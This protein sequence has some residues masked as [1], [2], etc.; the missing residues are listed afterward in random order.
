MCGSYYGL[1]NGYNTPCIKCLDSFCLY[2]G[3]NYS[4]CSACISGYVLVNL[5]CT[6]CFTTCLTC[7][8]STTNCTSCIMG[9]Y[10]SNNTCVKCSPNC[11]TCTN[12]T[13]CQNCAVGYFSPVANICYICPLVCTTCIFNA[14]LSMTPQC[15]L[16]VVDHINPPLCP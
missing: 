8:T 4:A 11:S 2:C 12:A 14:S 10:L 9:Y 5:T 1:T 15:L 16:C 7:Q 13:S 3:S 6:P